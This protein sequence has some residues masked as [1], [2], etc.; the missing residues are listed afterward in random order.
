MN[1]STARLGTSRTPPR[2]QSPCWSLPTT[3]CL[4]TVAVAA[5]FAQAGPPR[6]RAHVYPPVSDVES[7]YPGAFTATGEIAG[8]ASPEPFHPLSIA[9]RTSGTTLVEL[10]SD[11]RAFNAALGAGGA[12]GAGGGGLVVGMMGMAPAYWLNDVGDLLPPLPGYFQGAAWDAN[13][14]G[15]IVGIHTNDLFGVDIPVFW[16]SFEQPATELPNPGGLS[17]GGAAFAV[18]DAGQIAGIS[19]PTGFFQAVRWDSVTSDPV[20]IGPLRGGVG[21]EA[22]A[23]NA[24]GDVAGRTTFPSL[25]VRAML[26]LRAEDELIDLGVLGGSFS[27]ALGVNTLR[28]VVGVSSTA[29]IGHGFLWKE[30]V[31]YDLNDLTVATNVPFQSISMA[32]DID[33]VGR[34]AAEVLVSGMPNEVRRIALLTPCAVADLDCNGAVDGA[35]VGLLLSAWGGRGVADLDGDGSVD[36]ADLGALLAAWTG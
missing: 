36:G 21:G 35:D 2:V 15:L 6:Y 14:S 26:H 16:E 7:A 12:G 1:Q 9:A 25:E 32:V 11:Q 34:I 10:P 17:S 18:N 29:T 4:A 31:L 8:S 30:G 13:G 33:D 23:I 3:G 24:L 19:A 22:R 5:T 28:E 20:I 27:E